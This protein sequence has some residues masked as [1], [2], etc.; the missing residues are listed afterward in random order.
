[1]RMLL[2]GLIT[3]WPAMAAAA[4]EINSASLA[5]LEALSGVG[6]ALAAR[7]VEERAQRSFSGWADAQR[8]VKGL[9][10][11]VAAQLSEQGLMVNGELYRPPFALPRN[12]A[13]H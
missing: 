2:V 9:G 7:I 11:K 13:A 8:R 6:T 12:R 10:P 4:L 1:M 5:Q 3:L